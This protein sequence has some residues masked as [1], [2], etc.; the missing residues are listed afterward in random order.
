MMNLQKIKFLCS[1]L[2]QE[3]AHTL[4]RCLVTSDLHYCNVISAGLPK[5]LL[6]ILHKVQNITAKLV[7]GYNKYESSTTA[8][9][10]LHLLSIKKRMDFKILALVHKCLSR[11]APEY[12]KDL[13]IIHQGGR[14]GLCSAKDSKKLITPR[15]YYSTKLL[16]I[17]HS[18]YMDLKFGM[19]Y[20]VTYKKLKT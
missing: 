18:V 5:V 12:L 4:V 17:G 14:K 13:L 19:H 8:S 15:T 6:E 3:S 16:Q 20:Q 9:Q 7:Q 11:L 10:K 1:L 2:T